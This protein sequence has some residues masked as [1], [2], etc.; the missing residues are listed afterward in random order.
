MNEA[1]L[2]NLARVR[3][4]EHLRT[5]AGLARGRQLL[6]AKRRSRRAGRQMRKDARL[7]GRPHETARTAPLRPGELSAPGSARELV[8]QP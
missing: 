8:E 2:E 5:A 1:L 7:R 4:E 3:I 6:Q